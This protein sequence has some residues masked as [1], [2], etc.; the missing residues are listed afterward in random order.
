MESFSPA[1]CVVSAP[2]P[3]L[4]GSPLARGRLP[5]GG[6][7]FLRKGTLLLSKPPK[8]LDRAEPTLP[9]AALGLLTLDS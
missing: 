6:G 3:S 1:G 2:L 9:V 5:D 7:T 8:G 4:S